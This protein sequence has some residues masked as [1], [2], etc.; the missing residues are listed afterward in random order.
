MLKSRAT[1]LA[2]ELAAAFPG[3]SISLVSIQAWADELMGLDDAQAS[4][5]VGKLIHRCVDPPSVAQVVQ[6][7]D[8]VTQKTPSPRQE[9]DEGEGMSFAEYLTHHPE[10]RAQLQRLRLAR[11]P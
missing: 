5:V 6:C 4:E 2:G 10:A 7:R 8:E 11:K 1:K 9:L 3:R